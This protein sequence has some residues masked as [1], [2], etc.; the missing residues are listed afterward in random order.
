MISRYY[1]NLLADHKH[2][3]RM[4][5]KIELQKPSE[6]ETKLKLIKRLGRPNTNSIG[7]T[8]IQLIFNK[9]YSQIVHRH[10]TK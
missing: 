5:Q 2:T 6:Q 4:Y 3:C 8:F 7:S 9:W 10:Q 1:A